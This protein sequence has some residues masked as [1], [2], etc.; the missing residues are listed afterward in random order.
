MSLPPQKLAIYYGYPS[1][2]NSAGG[3]VPTAAGVFSQY[4]LV[5]FGSGLEDP[6]HPDHSN[7]VA[8][9]ADPQMVNTKIYGYIDAT[10]TL[11][12]IQNKIDLWCVMSVDGIF[13]DQFGY[14]FSV[15]RQKQREILWCVHCKGLSGFVNAWNPDDVFSAAVEPTHN[16][17]GLATRMGTDDIYL[18]ESFQVVN[19]E[20]D[21]NV[22][23]WQTKVQKMKSFRT[24]F[25]SKMATVSTWDSRAY[26]QAK[27]DYSYY[28]SA[29]SA[30]DYAGF[31][32][33]FFSASSASL[34]FRSRKEIRGDRLVGSLVDNGGVYENLTN[35]GIQVDTNNFTVDEILDHV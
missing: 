18:A 19:G 31:G 26:E 35:V 22:S 24:S 8:I 15:S 6:S 27:W 28:S 29:Q 21:A 12:Q 34:P 16:P 17:D 11:D 3:D 13:L 1:A 23:A 32:E 33:E 20:Y 2:V 4:D 14:D 30:F 10:L 5:V 25:S 7:T 9:I